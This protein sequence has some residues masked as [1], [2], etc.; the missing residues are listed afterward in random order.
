VTSVGTDTC[1]GRKGNRMQPRVRRQAGDRFSLLREEGRGAHAHACQE[2]GGAC[3]RVEER[4]DEQRF[5]MHICEK[6]DI[7]FSGICNP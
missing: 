5:G 6:F 4:L 3:I 7:Y 2:A 1:R